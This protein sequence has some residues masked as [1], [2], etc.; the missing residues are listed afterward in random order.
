MSNSPKK[1]EAFTRLGVQAYTPRQL[2]LFPATDDGGGTRIQTT[3]T[4]LEKGATRDDGSAADA[5]SI[6]E[7]RYNHGPRRYTD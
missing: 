7:A 3:R 5:R 6:T 4:G 2:E 1:V